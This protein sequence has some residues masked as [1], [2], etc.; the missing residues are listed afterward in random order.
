MT[1]ED[2]ERDE[3]SPNP[4]L[5]MMYLLRMGVLHRTS[6]RG[7]KGIQEVGSIQANRGQLPPS[8]SRSEGSYGNSEGHICLFDFESADEEKYKRTYHM[9]AEFFYKLKPVTIILKLNRAQL[10]EKLIPNSA[11]PKPGEK[12]YK[13]SLPLIET[14]Y[15][16][17][18]PVSAI[19]SYIVTCWDRE[20]LAFCQFP[21]GEIDKL[22]RILSLPE[23]E[24]V[25][26]IL[27]SSE[28]LH[29]E[30]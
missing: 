4:V 2:D 9:W 29:N 20:I 30:R 14:W 22:K 23:E 27:E 16:D 17:E 28:H 10:A 11:R 8:T 6:V 21:S 5:P 7:F 12:G 25:S 13:L 1:N 26:T 3:V 24:L 18:I 19:N 15:P